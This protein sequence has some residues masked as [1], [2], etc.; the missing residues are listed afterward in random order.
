[1]ELTRRIALGQLRKSV[2]GQIDVHRV[3]G[4]GLF[5]N[6]V[7]HGVT[8]TDSIGQPF[9]KA[10][11]ISAEYDLIGML[12]S[13]FGQ[14]Q[15]G[16]VRLYRPDVHLTRLPGDSLWNFDRIFGNGGGAPGRKRLVRFTDVE[17]VDGTVTVVQPFGP[18]SNAAL[19]QRFVLEDWP[20]GR[21]QRMRF[22]QV[23]G[24]FPDVTVMDPADAA[25]EIRVRRLATQAHVFKTALQVKD[26]EGR[27]T[28][29]DAAIGLDIDAFKFGESQGRVSGRIL[30]QEHGTGYDLEVT[31][32][33]FA[34]ED[35]SWLE[36][37]IPATG[38]ARFTLKIEG[39]AGEPLTLSAR[40]VELEAPGVRAAGGLAYITGPRPV[41][42][43][44]NLRIDQLDL[45]WLESRLQREIPIEGTLMGRVRADGPLDRL[46]TS[47]ELR[48]AGSGAAAQPLVRL[49]GGLG[50]NG[51]VTLREMHAEFETLDLA[52]LERIRPGTGLS[53]MVTGRADADGVLASG[54]QVR[55]VFRHEE[56]G[57]V[58]E[59]DGGGS[60]AV[61]AAGTRLNL[62]F[63]A[64]PLRLELIRR[65]ATQLDSLS[66][67]ARGRVGV[68]GSTDSLRITGDVVTEG[69][70]IVFDASIDRR[71]TAPRVAA[72]ASVRGFEPRL[73]RLLDLDARMSGRVRVDIAGR[74]AE[75]L[76][77]TIGVEVDSARVM[78]FPLERSRGY[79]RLAD[80]RAL[81]DSA[82][83]RAPGLRGNASGGLAL[84][85]SRSDSLRV[86]V[87]SESLEPLERIVFG[88]VRD[89]TMPRIDGAGN[90]QIT[91][92]GS[93]REMAISGSAALSHIRIDENNAAATQITLEALRA[94]TDSATFNIALASD[95][96]RVMGTFSDSARA[97]AV[98]GAR[99]GSI[100]ARAWSDSVTA[101]RMAVNFAE[102]GE[103]TEWRLTD[104]RFRSGTG[105]WQLAETAVL[106][107][108]SNSANVRGFRLVG[109]PGG[110]LNAAGNLA[111]YGEQQ[112]D[113]ADALLE[114]N[115][116]MSSV[117]VA[118]IPLAFRPPGEVDGTL[119]G[120]VRV[121]GTAGAPAI[122]GTLEAADIEYESSGLERVRAE[123]S[124]A[125]TRLALQA[126][127]FLEGR[128]V[129]TA[130][131]R[132]PVDLRFGPVPQRLLDQ[133]IDSFRVTMDSFPAAFVLGIV[134]AGFRDIQGVLDGAIDATGSPRDP[135]LQGALSLRGLA[136]TWDVTGVR[137]V[138]GNGLFDMNRELKTNVD[139]SAFTEALDGRT[140]RGSVRITGVIDLAQ[141]TNPDFD[142]QVDAVNALAAR[143]RDMDVTVSGTV[144]V[145]GHYMQPLLTGNVS[146][147]NSTMY[148]D[149]LYRQTQIVQFED[150]LLFE[151][152]DTT[153][154]A[155]SR[156]RPEIENPFI[157][158]LRVNQMG[159]RVG[160]NN[161]I[162]GR[163][164]NVELSGELTVTYN[165]PV[166][167]ILIS[168]T[169]NAM[170]GTY[171]LEYPPITRVFEVQEGSI[172]FP[173]TPGIDPVLNITALYTTR[174]SREP[175]NIYA[176]VQGTLTAPSVHLRSDVNP[177]ISES[178][179]ASY[180]FL[181][182]PTTAFGGTAASSG[183][184]GLFR[185]LGTGA[186]R[187]TG[188]GWVASGLQTLGQSIGLVDYVGVTAAE[189]S[190]G[191]SQLG[192]TDLLSGTQIEL[193]RYITPRL[194]VVYT[195]PVNAVSNTPGVRLEWRFNP[196]YS[197]ELFTEDRFARA[198]AFRY[199]EA[200]ARRVYG[201]LIVRSWNY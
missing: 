117:P 109:R 100:S 79:I 164:M 178:D 105:E 38:S 173:G 197:A 153:I 10:D 111:W 91:L 19:E 115:V 172:V 133:P 86:Q 158:N 20:G 1:M 195:Q 169:L 83:F 88:E 144:N 52:L 114:F 180:L 200:V 76:A 51:D 21:V 84:D 147:V 184:T 44:V 78:G 59:L 175:L 101:L 145:D 66:G 25:R 139:V 170:R 168:G 201:F 150:P 196:I 103:A 141:P 8:L 198:P 14:I 151:L 167:L 183:V 54:L 93:I 17:V 162:R 92:R 61:N 15:L 190:P 187:A 119:S 39:D 60:V 166:D 67:S 142:L 4:G 193:G 146:I 23:N 189:A 43:N 81:V 134:R 2:H 171:V 45:D 72:N 97:T 121:S 36:P 148:L 53:G 71:A 77:G 80:G 165:R 70:P 113:V 13:R 57:R 85:E 12:R 31:G 125:G 33:S 90:A 62:D 99:Q 75:E 163:E 56:A 127:A 192:L 40:D 186:L 24:E 179:L 116:H 69:G 124:Y 6:I 176:D 108:F 35:V 16:P 98:I 120:D 155:S 73:I 89:P 128:E 34:L 126:V 130:R 96:I 18:T 5:R 159:V 149:E 30:R 154:F 191:A 48:L 11:S 49:D 174:T 58:S 140:A 7:L 47:G 135:R 68:H 104:L 152:V 102:S 161:W 63:D 37:R 194:F 27:V 143:R 110:E 42:R 182:A 94:G 132:V 74:N 28:I 87:T 118:L 9:A 82:Y 50:M 107:L 177:P 32:R 64:R 138:G 199:S 3:S 123:L 106:Q 95:S 137:Y 29:E 55:T 41:F 65:F 26:A 131:G 112:P 22:E 129:L 136:A 122:S 185:G 181:N 156:V 188:L 160:P 46:Q 157:A